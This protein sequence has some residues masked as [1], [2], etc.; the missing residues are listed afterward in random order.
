MA[1]VSSATTIVAHNVNFDKNVLLSELYR[2]S[3]NTEIEILNTKIWKCTMER[4]KVLCGL[5]ASNKLKPPKLKEL[6][7]AL[8]I[9]E[10]A[11]RPFHNSKHDVYYTSKCYFA[12]QVLRN[13]TPMMYEGKHTGKTYE[14]IL[15]ED[16]MYAVL[17][18]AACNVHKLYNSPILKLSNWVKTQIPS[19]PAL[20]EEVKKKEEE[21]RNGLPILV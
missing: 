11:G 8:G 5:R 18:H 10:E 4:G 20:L 16:R 14:E 2:R 13:K 6:M 7:H 12:E 1:Q 15:K 3:K 21:I 17:A 19:D 9:K